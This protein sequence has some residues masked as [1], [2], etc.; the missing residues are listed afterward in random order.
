MKIERLLSVLSLLTSY[1][2][3][4]ARELAE[5]LEVSKRTIY[6]DMDTLS[7]AGIPIVSYAGIHGG[8]GIMSGYKVSKTIFSRQEMANI[9]T[10]LTAIQSISESTEL[11][12]LV[13]K[14]APKKGEQLETQNNLIIDLSTWSKTSQKQNKIDEIRKTIEKRQLLLIY[15]HSKNKVTQRKIECYKLIFKESDWY[16]Y[17]FCLKRNAFRFFKLTRIQKYEQLMARFEPREIGQIDLQM[18]SRNYLSHNLV[19]EK[20]QQVVLNYQ[21]KD[22]L[23]LID[24]IGS[25]FFDGEDLEATSN[26]ICFPLIDFE[27]TATFILR[28]QD[29]VKVIAPT[30]LVEIVKEKIKKMYDLYKS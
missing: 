20:E 7:R 17:A 8:F 6:R 13:S 16:L 4:S 30:I 21:Q 19:L 10:G 15:Y 5:R 26:S 2:C 25:E 14:I 22:R 28:L 1:D 23:F 29:K 18:D 11:S 12:T 3:L 9:L 24:K 27:Q